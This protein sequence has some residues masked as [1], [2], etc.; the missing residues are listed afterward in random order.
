[1]SRLAKKSVQIPQGVE[2]SVVDGVL[3][4]KGG[5]GALEVSVLPFTQVSVDNGNIA[6]SLTKKT[7]QGRANLGTMWSLANN[8]V[9]GANEGFSKTL[10]IDGVGFR[11]SVE[12]KTLVLNVGFSHPVKFE[13][14]D[15]VEIKTEKNTITISGINK[16][17]VGQVAADI[18]KIKK[19][20]PYKGKGIRYQDEIVRRK[21]G[22]KVAGATAG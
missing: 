18:R 3:K 8:A 6:V 5:K 19:P 22:K 21:A 20:E 7:K 12:G 14:P 9:I 17:L 15:G 4:V 13:T 16:A 10:V 11:V 2:T 1:M